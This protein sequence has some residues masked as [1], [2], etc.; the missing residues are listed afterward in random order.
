MPE[1]HEESKRD[2]FRNHQSQRTRQNSTSRGQINVV[3]PSPLN[4]LYILFN[5]MEETVRV[6]RDGRLIPSLASHSYWL[7]DH[8]LEQQLRKGVFFHDGQPFTAHELYRS[9]SE[10]RR[11]YA[12][13]PP[14]T[15]LNIPEGT[16]LEVVDDYTVRFHLPEKDGLALAKMRGIHVGNDIFWSELGFGYKTRGSGESHW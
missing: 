12:P 9:F 11:W 14:G 1:Y 2:S 16:K 10:E 13:H 4:W 15:W 7:D 5:T 3:D 6:N 8:T